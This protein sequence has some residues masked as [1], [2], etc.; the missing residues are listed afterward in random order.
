MEDRPR[1]PMSMN[2]SDPQS[3]SPTSIDAE[4]IR[5][6]AKLAH[7]E[8]DDSEAERFAHQ[9]GQIIDYA[10]SIQRLET[11]GVAPTSH[12]LL[13]STQLLREDAPGSDR[14]DRDELLGAAPQNGHGLFKVP[15]VLP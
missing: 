2:E 3:S 6:L 9:V 13:K 14:V 7:L 11:A 8:L 5:K 10:Q 12:A 4:E 1:H 15:K